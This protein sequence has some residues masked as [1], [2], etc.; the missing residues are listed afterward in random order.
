VIGVNTA[1]IL[2]AQGICF[3]IAVDPA[4]RGQASSATVGSWRLIGVAARTRSCAG[5]WCG[6]TVARVG[7]AGAVGREGQSGRTHRPA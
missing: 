4:V 7:G 1:M 5:T 2:P 6:G 3:A